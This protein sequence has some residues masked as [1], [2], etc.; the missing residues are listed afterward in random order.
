MGN[1]CLYDHVAY[2]RRMV[3]GVLGDG[4]GFSVMYIL[5]NIWRPILISRIGEYVSD[6]ESATVLSIESQTKS[7]AAVLLAPAL[8]VAVDY[9]QL[10]SLGQSPFWPVGVAG[11][12]L[13]AFFFASTR[14]SG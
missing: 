2:S 13:S 12:I 11:V 8:G 5:Q 10:H 3:R 14:R 4:W 6:N 9:C 7:F 1:Y